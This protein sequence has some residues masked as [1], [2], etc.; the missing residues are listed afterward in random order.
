MD[1]MVVV[2]NAH[3]KRT[4]TFNLISYMVTR[5]LARASDL[6]AQLLAPLLIR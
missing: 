3:H 2:F 4:H 1:I 5:W 6:H